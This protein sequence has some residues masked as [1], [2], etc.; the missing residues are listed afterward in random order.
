MSIK[1]VADLSLLS[2]AAIGVVAS[3]ERDREKEG[4]EK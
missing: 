1:C 3:R 4:Q 2:F